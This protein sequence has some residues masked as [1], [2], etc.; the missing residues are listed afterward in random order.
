MIVPF[1]NLLMFIRIL[2]VYTLLTYFIRVQNFMV[3]LKTDWPG[4]K[5]VV[6][7]NLFI[8]ILGCS[9][10]VF[11]DKIGD[12][13]RYSGSFCAMIY[14]F[15]LPC[16]LQMMSQHREFGKIPIWSWILHPFLI[17][18]GIFNFIAQF[19]IQAY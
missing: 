6:I 15:F 8:V 18:L 9:M 2:T 14:M 13:I 7:T 3:I 11:Y 12:I 4:L 10:A 19:T 17:I 1:L 16:T 5:Y